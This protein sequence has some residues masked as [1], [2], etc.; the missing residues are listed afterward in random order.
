MS[1]YSY[2]AKDGSK[3]SVS[4][5]H[6]DMALAL[7]LELQKNSPSRICNWSRHKEM[8]EKEGFLDSDKNENYRQ[9]VK[10]Y[11]GQMA[12]HSN[13]HEAVVFKDSGI[14]SV[15]STVGEMAYEKRNAQNVLRELNSL[16]RQLIDK[17]LFFEEIRKEVRNVVGD[18][19][20]IRVGLDSR[21]TSGRRLILAVTDWHIGAIVDT[22]NNTYDF[23]TAVRCIDTLIKK[24]VERAH[25]EGV[26]KV[27][28]VYMGDMLEHLY[29]RASQG[30]GTEMTL[31]KQITKGA[32]LLIKLL[33]S[34]ASSGFKVTY[35]GFAGNHDRIEGD[36]KKS[37][38]NDNGMIMVNE[39]VKATVES[40]PDIEFIKCGGYSAQML[41]VNGRNIK[42]VHG[43]M[44]KRADK[45]KLQKHSFNDDVSYDAIIMGHYHH[46]SV[47]EVA[48]DKFEVIVGSIKGS[49]EYSDSLGLSSSRSQLIIVVDEEGDMSFKKV[50]V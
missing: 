49:D 6:L 36:K 41:D 40:E 34:I 30:F 16:K 10:R 47:V 33:K 25:R 43:D 8:M 22:D 44:E 2:T 3:V 39:I 14:K 7:K 20:P 42:F 31:S 37:V 24:T 4:I 15:K 9:L 1:N 32:G 48:Q 27:E 11:Q 38:H 12:S 23:E 26:S 35:Q 18:I 45:S 17:S 13:I 50:R 5:E 46:Y 28:V 29:M 21:E 19:A